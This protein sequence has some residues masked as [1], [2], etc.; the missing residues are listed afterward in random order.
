[1]LEAMQMFAVLFGITGIALMCASLY[2]GAWLFAVINAALIG[3]NAA[4]YLILGRLK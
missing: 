1:M 2:Q 4:S 3:I